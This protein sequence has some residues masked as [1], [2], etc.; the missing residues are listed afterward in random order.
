MADPRRGCDPRTWLVGESGSAVPGVDRGSV[1]PRDVMHA[2]T[3]VVADWLTRAHDG[4]R[5][6]V[7]HG[8]TLAG[9][10]IPRSA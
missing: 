5:T 1:D 8:R 10:L 3:G 7:L 4:E 2:R 9:D 6:A